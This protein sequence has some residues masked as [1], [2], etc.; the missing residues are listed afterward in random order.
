MYDVLVGKGI[1]YARN[2]FFFFATHCLI[3]APPR[4]IAL[5]SDAHA[6]SERLA[7]MQSFVQLSFSARLTERGGMFFRD[8]KLVSIGSVGEA[9]SLST[10]QPLPAY[11]QHL[12]HIHTNGDWHWQPAA[13]SCIKIQQLRDRVV[14][15]IDTYSLI[16]DR[17]HLVFAYS[18]ELATCTDL[19]ALNIDAFNAELARDMLSS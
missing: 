5:M 2:F 18:P 17:N 7:S 15:A 9:V 3:H 8:G 16:S 11:A 10:T 13:E 12:T 14:L 4:E 19:R 6:S 1:V